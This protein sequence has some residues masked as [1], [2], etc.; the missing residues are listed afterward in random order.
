MF[1]HEKM[2]SVYQRYKHVYEAYDD[3]TIVGTL[4][5]PQDAEY[6]AEAYGPVGLS[7][8]YISRAESYQEAILARCSLHPRQ[9][10]LRFVE[11]GSEVDQSTSSELVLC[12]VA[13]GRYLSRKYRLVKGDRVALCFAPGLDF[14]RAFVSC[15]LYGLFFLGYVSKWHLK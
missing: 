14:F 12:A 8:A 5:S 9:V 6:Y 13:I 15:V 1:P 10:I 11:N 7:A 4:Q 2:D 3:E